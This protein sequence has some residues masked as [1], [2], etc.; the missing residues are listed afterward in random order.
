MDFHSYRQMGVLQRKTPHPA[1]QTTVAEVQSPNF[2]LAGD[3]ISRHAAEYLSFCCCI[4]FRFWYGW[5]AVDGRKSIA[6]QGV[7]YASNWHKTTG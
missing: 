6:P 4:S 5:S 3:R 2:L 7:S 1:T